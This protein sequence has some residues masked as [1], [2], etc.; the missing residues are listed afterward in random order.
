MSEL[1]DRIARARALVRLSAAELGELAGMS[2]AV[3]GMIET[4]RRKTPAATTVSKIAGVLGVSSDWLISGIGDE[5]TKEQVSTAV[6]LARIAKAEP[7]AAD[8]SSPDSS[9]TPTPHSEAS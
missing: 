3:V 6:A 2:D 8:E 5:P 4:D 9:S 7:D 1:G